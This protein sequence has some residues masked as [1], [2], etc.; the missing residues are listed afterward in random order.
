V[1]RHSCLALAAASGI[2]ENAGLADRAVQTKTA[3]STYLGCPEDALKQ[4]RSLVP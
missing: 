1:L 3:V 2:L 4:A